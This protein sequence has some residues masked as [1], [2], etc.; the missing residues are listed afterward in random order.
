MLAEKITTHNAHLLVEFSH[1]VLFDH[2]GEAR[3]TD[4]LALRR[5][6]WIAVSGTGGALFN[7][8][9]RSI[10]ADVTLELWTDTPPSPLADDQQQYE[11]QFTT[12]SGQVLLSSVT[13]SPND[14]A[15]QLP[16]PGTYQLRARRLGETVNHDEQT[17]SWLLQT[18]PA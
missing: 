7:A 18:W 8:S 3:T 11:G 1:F 13:G 15:V 2:S 12:D 6:G 4:L 10:T 14:V 17:E 5:P 9:G 16:G